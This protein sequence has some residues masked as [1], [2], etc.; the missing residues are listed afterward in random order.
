MAGIV[1]V[2]LLEVR[3]DTGRAVLHKWGAAPS[4]LLSSRGMEKLGIPAPP[5]GLSALDCGEITLSFSL[6]PGDTLIMVSDGIGE[7]AVLRSGQ[8][9]RLSPG[10]LARK[11][12]QDHAGLPQDDA[13]A[14]T[15][16]L[17]PA[18]DRDAG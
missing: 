17:V 16:C 13:T 10:E 8:G 2:D 3:L 5:P 11:I 7:D 12:L 4:Y 18:A 14:M 15:V 6:R 1:T 9:C